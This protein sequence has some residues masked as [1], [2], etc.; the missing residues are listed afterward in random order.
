MAVAYWLSRQC[1][2]R[3]VAEGTDVGID[4]FCETVEKE[5]KLPFLHFWVQVKSGKQV[6]ETEERKGKC[7][8][9]AE[10]IRYWVR[11]PVP[12]YAFLVPEDQIPQ[13][14]KV[15][16]IDFV[17]Q[18][19]NGQVPVEGQGEKTL[20]SDHVFAT[21]GGSDNLETFVDTIVRVDHVLLRAREGVCIPLPQQPQAYIRKH[22]VGFRAP[23]ARTIA[24]QVRSSASYT[25]AD[26]LSLDSPTFDQKRC[27]AVLA[28]VLRPFAQGITDAAYWSTH[29]EDHIAYGRWLRVNGQEPAA[30]EQF[31][32]AM[33]SIEKDEGFQCGVPNWKEMVE[34]IK[35]LRDG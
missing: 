18:S 15:F 9:D 32:K 33:N 7:Q 6:K 4:L 1:L 3:P 22:L 11:Q 20:E 28:D 21:V 29:W 30:K 14:N 24:E 35:R 12:V 13:M 2:V 27:M 23:L 19:L 5:S 8:F 25:L 16:V 10:H 17:L 31:T 34:G 26:L